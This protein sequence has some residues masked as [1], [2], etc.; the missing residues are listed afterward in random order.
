MRLNPLPLFYLVLMLL[1]TQSFADSDGNSSAQI[2]GPSAAAP[3]T[4]PS[5][6]P[7]TPA[8]PPPV[9]QPI[10]VTVSRSDLDERRQSTAAKTVVGREE[11]LKFGDT[12]VTD[13]L[14]RLPGITIGG[15]PGRGG[16]IRMRGLGSG[17]TQILINGERIPQGFSVDQLT[18]DQ[19]ERIEIMRAP[20]A[21]FGARAIAGTINI[22]LRE[23]LKNKQFDELRSSLGGEQG[24]VQPSVSWSSNNQF[25][26]KGSYTV[27]ASLYH[28][29]DVDQSFTQTRIIDTTSG[30][31]DL[32]QDESS[33]TRSLSNGM[34]LSGR[35]KLPLENGD[36][37]SFQPFALLSQGTSSALTHLNQ[38]IALSSPNIS[39]SNYSASVT[40]AQTQSAIARM[41]G[42][43]ETRINDLTKAQISFGLGDSYHSSLSQRAELDGTGATIKT[44]DTH[45]TINDVSFNTKGKVSYPWLDNHQWVGG[46][47]LEKSERS[48]TYTTLQNGSVEPGLN[49]VGGN[50][51]ASTELKALYAQDEVDINPHWS[52]YAGLRVEQ[53]DTHSDSSGYAGHNTSSV[54]TPLLHAVWKPD[55]KRHDQIRISLTRTYLSPTLNQ[56]SGL[57]VLSI[58]PNAAVSPDS[59]G[60]PYLKPQLATGI[61]LAYENYLSQ[62][63]LV[64]VSTFARRISNL[65]RTVTSLQTV[66][67]SSSPRWVS[68]PTNVGG[69][70]TEGIELE[71]KL[72]MDELI[73]KGPKMS[74]R[75]TLSLFRS[76]VEYIQGPNN[77]LDQQ[78]KATGNLGG[79]YK[80]RE[81]PLT[82]GTNINWTPNTFIQSTADQASFSSVKIVSDLYGVWK[83]DPNSSLRLSASNFL[84]MHY[85][86][87]SFITV[88]SFN[89]QQSSQVLA[90]T[91]TL[92][93][94]KWE[95]KF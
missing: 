76:Q 57:P 45:S 28:H 4:D 25:G 6:S 1:S 29:D 56:L 83:F 60:N 78:P 16:E 19:I 38:P 75:A 8:V 21:E 9:L 17:Y 51:T 82:L 94:A 62:S 90:N 69:A 58:K 18:P 27:S 31:T 12:S 13:V 68:E 11:I 72:Q 30:A 5:P 61:D 77:R 88:P 74:L 85:N 26:P 54:W 80:F 87:S 49:T 48:Q 52:A 7:A 15:K 84:P 47:E 23:P 73:E 2:A 36:Q 92:L 20:T 46:W 70:M 53:I 32:L 39:P 50:L 22:V 37:L 67:W 33:R 93:Q 43:W 41:N 66:P 81:I 86:T 44:L 10:E 63:S 34:H 71:A 89:Q 91:H 55:A 35:L 64:S 14:K 65:I 3:S 42:Q 40:G 59:A 79:D 24:R 95:W